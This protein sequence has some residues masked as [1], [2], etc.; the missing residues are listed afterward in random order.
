MDDNVKFKNMNKSVTILLDMILYMCKS[1]ITL[2]LIDISNGIN[3]NQATTLRYLNAL[4]NEGYA[5]QTKI[6]Q[7]Y[8]LTWKISTFN[9]YIQSYSSI[10][11]LSHDIISE[12]TNELNFGIALVIEQNME[13]VYLDCI[14]KYDQIG[15]DLIR[16]GKRTPMHSS[17]SGKLF[18]S[19]YTDIKLDYFINE[20]N[21]NKL[22]EKTITTKDDL[23]K[24]LDKV[25]YNGYSID[26]EECEANLRCVSVPIFDY[27]D[28]IVAAISSFG[29]TSQFTYEVIKNDVLPLLKKAASEISFRLGGKLR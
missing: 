10:N 16:I 3:I 13:C 21:L 8:G 4:I 27:Q 18:L 5:Y 24:E 23:I 2:R 14:Y 17:G 26:D 22:T 25:R 28:R 11:T 15:F 1:H 7:R 20:K 19:E 9:D 6:T 29:S 12:L